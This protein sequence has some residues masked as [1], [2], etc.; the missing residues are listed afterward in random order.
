MEQI[1]EL[2][3]SLVGPNGKLNDIYINTE[4]KKK[5]HSCLPVTI[6]THT[7]RKRQ[8]VSF[9]CL[10]VGSVIPGAAVTPDI[11]TKVSDLSYS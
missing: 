7:V 3:V 5:S 11:L 6:K 1:N 2:I 10:L 9:M 8:V 4:K